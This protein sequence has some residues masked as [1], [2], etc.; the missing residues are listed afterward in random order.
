ML[1][2]YFKVTNNLR[3]TIIPNTTI[4]MGRRGYMFV[5]NTKIFKKTFRQKMKTQKEDGKMF[6]FEGIIVI[7]LESIFT[8]I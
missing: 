8:T 7:R 1:S 4:V 6:I 3:Q 5:L 2:W